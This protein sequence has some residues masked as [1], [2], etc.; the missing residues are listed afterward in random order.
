[1]TQLTHCP[2]VSCVSGADYGGINKMSPS[3]LGFL[4]QQQQQQQQQHNDT[5]SF[6]HLPNTRRTAHP[7]LVFFLFLFLFLFLARVC[8]SALVHGTGELL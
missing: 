8:T 6:Q 4:R 7:L 3:T 5:N 2:I 1:M